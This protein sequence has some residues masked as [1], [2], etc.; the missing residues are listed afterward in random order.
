[1]TL[2]IRS[3][4]LISCTSASNVPVSSPNPVVLSV[5]T[6]HHLLN[7]ATSLRSSALRLGASG[8]TKNRD[9]FSR[10]DCNTR[11]ELC[12]KHSSSQNIPPYFKLSVRCVGSCCI[13]IRS[14]SSYVIPTAPTKCVSL[15][16]A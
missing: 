7:G 10:S 11:A 5:I 6:Y 9:D 8:N 1:M 2:S 15:V 12:L 4:V 13:L 14:C 16:S 3:S